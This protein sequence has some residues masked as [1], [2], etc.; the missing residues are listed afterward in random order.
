MPCRT[1]ASGCPA[2]LGKVRLARLRRLG[3]VVVVV[4]VEESWA[5]LPNQKV[6]LCSWALNR[7]EQHGLADR[8]NW[9]LRHGVDD[10]WRQTRMRARPA[11]EKLQ[12]DRS[13]NEPG[14]RK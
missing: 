5:K 4:V 3:L 8:V 2:V 11:Q 14:K 13:H 9:H 7:W 1:V 6:G 10:V 12:S